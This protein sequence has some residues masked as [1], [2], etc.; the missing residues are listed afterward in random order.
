MPPASADNFNEWVKMIHDL[1]PHHTLDELREEFLE[2]L[3]SKKHKHFLAL[4]ENGNYLGFINLSLRSDYVQGTSSK[5][6]VYVEGIYVKPEYR[7]QGVTKQLI[8]QA[9]K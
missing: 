1:W 7:K 9:E 8:H 6:V 4:D 2:E 3:G 5:P